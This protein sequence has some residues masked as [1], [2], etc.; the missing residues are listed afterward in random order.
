M[1]ATEFWDQKNQ[2]VLNGAPIRPSVSYVNNHISGKKTDAIRLIALLEQNGELNNL[3]PVELKHRIQNKSQRAAFYQ[4]L[5]SLVTQFSNHG[6][7]GN[8]NVYKVDK[9]FTLASVCRSKL[10]TP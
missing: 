9:P 3:S 5:D 1:F 8:A 4:Y 2:K 7:K 10:T 6:K